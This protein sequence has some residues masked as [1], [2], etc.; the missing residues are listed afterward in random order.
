MR[1]KHESIKAVGLFYAFIDFGKTLLDQPKCWVIPSTTV[2]DVLARAHEVWLETPGAKGQQ[3]KDS[4]F[5]RFLPNYDA[6]GIQIGCG[7]GW[8]DQYR[9]N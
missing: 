6:K 3:R 7:I 2:A 4:D 1:S 5:R 9:E 8:L